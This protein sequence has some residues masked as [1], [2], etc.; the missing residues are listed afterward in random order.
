MPASLI[1]Q[2]RKTL[3]ALE[4]QQRAGDAQIDLFAPP[5]APAPLLERSALDHALAAIEPDMLSP[6][7]ALEALYRLKAI[8]LSDLTPDNESQP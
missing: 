1:R 7:E 3:E 6:K 5:T 4:S 2:A 8:H